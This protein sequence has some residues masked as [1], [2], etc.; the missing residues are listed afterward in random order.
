MEMKIENVAYILKTIPPH[1][2]PFLTRVGELMI[3]KPENFEESEKISQELEKSLKK[4][5][6]ACVKPEPES[7]HQYALFKALNDMTIKTM[8]DAG[9]F[10]KTRKSNAEESSAVSSA[11]A[12]APK[13]I[14][15]PN[16]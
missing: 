14:S 1:L 2:A 15:K 13:R 6:D 8:K 3:K 11:A 9:F 12:Q 7:T 10:R 16:G 5:F 4:L